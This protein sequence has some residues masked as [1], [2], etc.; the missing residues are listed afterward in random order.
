MA[1]R[2][3]NLSLPLAELL[4]CFTLFP[5]RTMELL[6]VCVLFA[7]P[8]F[9]LTSSMRQLTR[10]AVNFIGLK[11][12]HLSYVNTE[13]L[14]TSLLLLVDVVYDFPFKSLQ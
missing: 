7:F 5:L 13:T 11:H 1:C 4:N 2:R 6:C 9:H 12:E 10:F 14:I 3:S 8:F